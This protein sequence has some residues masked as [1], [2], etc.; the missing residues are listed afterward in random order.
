MTSEKDKIIAKVYYDLAGYG[1][2]AATL[3]DA[4][5]YNSNIT[6]D[7]VK[8]WKERNTERKTSLRGFNVFLVDFSFL[9][10]GNSK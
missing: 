6:Y 5:K 3:E 1:S 7:D 4:K 9:P 8:R 2:V 10:P